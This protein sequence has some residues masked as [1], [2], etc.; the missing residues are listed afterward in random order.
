MN[1]FGVT[2]WL[3][4]RAWFGS[5]E[6][7]DTT[8]T[9]KMIVPFAIFVNNNSHN[10]KWESRTEHYL[11]EELDKLYTNKL[12][13]LSSWN[14]W[15]SL[16]KNINEPARLA[17]EGKVNLHSLSKEIG[18]IERTYQLLKLEYKGLK[19]NGK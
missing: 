8:I 7:I 6:T 2:E 4:A 17:F 9:N 3:K 16:I 10:T 13:K 11:I 15:V 1:V 19:Y 18:D 12:S 14:S 5:R